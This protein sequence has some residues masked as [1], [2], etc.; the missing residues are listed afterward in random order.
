MNVLILGTGAREHAIGWKLKQQKECNQIWIHPGNAGIRLL[1]FPDLGSAHTVHDLIS[2][3]KANSIDLVVVGPEKMLEQ[4]IADAFRKEGFLVV[5]PNREAARLETSKVF[6]KTFMLE[7]GIPTASFHVFGSF[8]ELTNHKNQ[9]WPWVLKLDGLAAGKGV[10]IA[11]SEEEV[12]QF[13][14]AVWKK[15]QFGLGPHQVLTESFIQGREISY[16]GFCD[17]QNFI[18]LAS[19]TDHKRVFDGNEGANTG[20]MGAISPSPFLT[21][22]IESEINKAVILP[23]LKQIKASALDFR[24]VLFVGL[25]INENGSPSVLEFNTRFGDPETQCVFPRLTSS[26]LRLLKATAE[27]QLNQIEAPSWDSRSSVYVVACS[28]GYPEAPKLGDAVSG[29]ESLPDDALVFFSGVAKQDSHLVSNGGRV[30]GV[31]AMELSLLDARRKAYQL[32]SGIQWR[33]IHFRRDIGL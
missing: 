29:L 30:L 7:A 24:G 19:A 32:L 21:P 2:R 20:G 31:G 3:A 17:G 15:Q 9:T 5:G 22:Q 8:Q 33:G 11:H 14:E 26:L 6:A 4:G 28:E 27:G 16:I 10:V 18:P 23:F 12:H 1:G 13:A 25:M